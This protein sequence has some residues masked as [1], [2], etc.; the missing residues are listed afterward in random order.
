MTLA[1][2]RFYTSFSPDLRWVALCIFLSGIAEGLSINLHTLYIEYLGADPQQVGETL[3]L[4]GV[5]TIF[6][7]IP[8]GFLAD[9]GRRKP[10]ILAAWLSTLITFTWLALAPDWRWAIPGFMLY[11]LGSFARPVFS[12]Y[13]AAADRGN[14][15]NRVFATT[16]LSWSLG[17]VFSPALGGWIGEHFGLRAV[18]AASGV[19]YLISTL[20]LLPLTEQQATPG[21]AQ[22]VRVGRILSNRPFLRQVAVIMFILFATNL[23]VILAPNYLQQVKGLSV[24]QVGGLGTVA[25]IGLM[26]MTVL[27]GRLPAERRRPLLIVQ[28]ASG[29]ALVLIL[30]SPAS[31]GGALPLMAFSAYFFR[32]G[33]DA[34]WTPTAGRLSLWLPPEIRSLGFGF[35]D[36]AIRIALTLAPLA[37]GQLYALDP[38]LPLLAGMAAVASSVLLT[39]TLPRHRPAPEET[40]L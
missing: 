19:V 6:V 36:T 3:A 34:I 23:G 30:L 20:C 21:Q 40:R 25:S 39:L 13:I 8:A 22:A 29:L 14:N 16:S 15:L 35:R 2:R 33:I 10:I 1:L 26:A 38:A 5:I 32:G 12:A 17:S 31:V 27:Q 7:Y 18:F 4:A 24:Q 11:T 28:A 37:A 9:R